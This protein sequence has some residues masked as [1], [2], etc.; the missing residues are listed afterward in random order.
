MN[1]HTLFIKTPKA[2]ALTPLNTIGLRVYCVIWTVI[3]WSL[4]KN[5]CFLLKQQLTNLSGRYIIGICQ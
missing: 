1:D 2:I 5:I 3:D 4:I